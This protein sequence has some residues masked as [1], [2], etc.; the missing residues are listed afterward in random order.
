MLD[1]Q[2]E[3]LEWKYPIK[4]RKQHTGEHRKLLL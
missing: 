4:D 2:S 1:V 3:I